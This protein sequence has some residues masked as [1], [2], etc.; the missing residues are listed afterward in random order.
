M[1]LIHAF[2]VVTLRSRSPGDPD[3]EDAGRGGRGVQPRRRHVVAVPHVERHAAD[4][5]RVVDVDTSRKF[6]AGH[7]PGAAWA[8]RGDLSGARV[9]DRR[10]AMRHAPVSVAVSDAVAL[11]MFARG[12]MPEPDSREPWFV[13]EAH[14]EVHQPDAD[15]L[16]VIYFSGHGAVVDDKL[17]AISGCAAATLASPARRRS[18]TTRRQ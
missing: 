1:A 14:A 18:A 2:L 8:L 4:D 15:D 11:G 10:G 12:A 6:L 16:V 13:C 17:G 9:L 3:D 7:V 5:A